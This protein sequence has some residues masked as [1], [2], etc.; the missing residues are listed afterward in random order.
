MYHEAVA[1]GVLTIG[2]A[3]K[4]V[5]VSADTIRHYERT[6]LLPRAPRT[7]GG[8]RYYSETAAALSAKDA[9]L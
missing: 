3:A 6:G 8:Y 5:G 1:G 4:R 2:E 7:A 9:S